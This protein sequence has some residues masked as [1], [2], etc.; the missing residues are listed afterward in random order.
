[1]FAIVEDFVA[2]L[3]LG[4]LAARVGPK[5]VMILNFSGFILSWAWMVCVCETALQPLLSMDIKLIICCH[6]LFSQCF[7][8]EH[9]AAGTH[10]HC[11]RGR[12][13]CYDGP[14]LF[15]GSYIHEEPVRLSPRSVQLLTDIS[16]Q[17]CHFLHSG[18]TDSNLSTCWTS[19]WFFN[20]NAWSICSLLLH[21]SSGLAFY[22]PDS[23]SSSSSYIR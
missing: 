11:L 19:G 14:D 7:Q 13:T 18:G 9:G 4:F 3:P 5:P 1:M 21:I 23:M 6:R 17:Y 10:V 8:C 12:L 15:R 2:T 20:A 22:T 16:L